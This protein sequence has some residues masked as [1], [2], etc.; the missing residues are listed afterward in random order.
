MLFGHIMSGQAPYRK[1]TLVETFDGARHY[2]RS[3]RGAGVRR[4]QELHDGRGVIAKVRPS[5]SE[6]QNM[7]AGLKG[8]L[9]LE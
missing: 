2:S 8:Q 9:H 6:M 3:R 4:G 1:L 7:R 5:R